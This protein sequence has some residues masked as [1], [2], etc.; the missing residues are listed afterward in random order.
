MRQPQKQNFRIA[1]VG[2]EF[3]ENLSLRY[4]AGSLSAA[5]YE[6]VFIY[7][8]NSILEAEN[9]ADEIIRNKIDLVG[10]SMAF[11]VRAIDDMALVQVLRKR[12]FNKHITAGGQFAT[13]H[14]TEIFHDCTGLDSVVRFEAESVITEL[15]G[16]LLTSANLETVSGLVW[17]NERN[18]IFV[19]HATP[20]PREIDELPL[21]LRKNKRS[22]FLGLKNIQ[23]IG[24]RGCHATCKY[25]CVSALATERRLASRDAGGSNAIPGTRRRTAVSVANEIAMLY[26]K[27]D[28][29]IFEFQDDNWIHPKISIAV[30]YFTELKNEL[31]KKGVGQIGLTLKTRADSV[32]PEIIGILKEIG[33]IRVFVGIESGTQNLLSQLGR[34]TRDN[35]S[36]QALQILRDFKIP[37]Y[38]NALLFGPDIRSADIEPELEFL[39]KCADFPFEI[40]EVVIYG[41]TGL[42]LSLRDENRLHGNYLDYEYDYLDEHTQRMHAII[43]RLE[44]RHFG[45]Y[46]PIKMAADLGFNLGLLQVF[47]PGTV[48]NSFAEKVEELNRK[49]NEDQIR[50]IRKA[51]ELAKQELPVEEASE[52]LIA[53]TISIDLKF[54]RSII[55]LHN[56]IEF[57]VSTITKNRSVKSYYRIGAIVQSGLVASLFLMSVNKLHAQAPVY[58]PQIEKDLVK[59]AFHYN[60]FS[61]QHVKRELKNS[62][63]PIT[64][65]QNSL[66]YDVDSL[67]RSGNSEYKNTDKKLWKLNYRIAKL[68]SKRINEDYKRLQHILNE[69]NPKIKIGTT[70]KF[71]LDNNGYVSDVQVTDSTSG[72]TLSP[73]LKKEILDLLK[74]KKFYAYETKK[75]IHHAN[76]PYR[77]SPRKYRHRMKRMRRGPMD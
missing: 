60:W 55:E 76:K 16:V 3:E 77:E 46:S 26:F 22:E 65:Y 12:G 8:Y 30:E 31:D 54:Y 56:E 42:Y 37:A 6:Q 38:F 36:L 57:H 44:T 23:M 15:A 69:H 53:E 71:Y 70:L 21:P 14:Y 67:T 40:V 29:R 2:V 61:W 9:I 4:L 47:Y 75:Y 52:R 50:I 58:N 64:Q 7:P 32:Q 66:K 63:I 45:V 74:E 73:E 11:Q 41:K 33:L 39:E 28:V 49:I 59:L 43:S 1:L 10:V 51:F 34:K 19:N 25:C 35:V 18:E 17:K 20:E 5:G 27:H 24:S 68:E 62:K 48:A 13:L 72:A